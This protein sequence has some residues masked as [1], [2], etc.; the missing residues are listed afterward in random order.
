L[1]QCCLGKVDLLEEQKR[2]HRKCKHYQHGLKKDVVLCSASPSG[3]RDTQNPTWRTQESR[4][5]SK[6]QSGGW[7]A[8]ACT[9]P[10]V[11]CRYC[12]SCEFNV[13]SRLYGFSGALVSKAMIVCVV[14]VVDAPCWS[15]MRETETTSRVFGVTWQLIRGP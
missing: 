14:L 13:T 4:T 1:G 3:C 6:D 10:G 5:L 8:E 2:E 9:R 7:E 11:L 12:G 15:Y